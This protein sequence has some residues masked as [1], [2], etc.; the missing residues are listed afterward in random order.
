MSVATG[1]A[2]AGMPGLPQVWQWEEQFVGF[3]TRYTGS[4]G[5]AAYVDWLAGSCPRCPASGCG[6]TG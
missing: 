2:A 4:S 1:G 5:H 6:R 3:G